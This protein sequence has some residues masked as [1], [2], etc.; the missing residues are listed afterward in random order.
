MFS[1]IFGLVCPMQVAIYS[2]F[3]C[4]TR[5]L[6]VSVRLRIMHLR[7]CM[8]YIGQVERVFGGSDNSQYSPAVI[9]SNLQIPGGIYA[10]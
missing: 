1:V 8:P 4:K 6:Y 2:H 3:I 5:Q 10:S 9:V 7:A